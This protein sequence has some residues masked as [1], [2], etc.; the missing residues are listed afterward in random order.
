MFYDLSFDQAGDHLPEQIKSVHYANRLVGLKRTIILQ[1]V[2][3]YQEEIGSVRIECDE[4]E[5]SDNEEDSEVVRHR[6]VFVELDKGTF[7]IARRVPVIPSSFLV[8]FMKHHTLGI[9][10]DYG[11]LGNMI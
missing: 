6:K 2:R 1:L 3:T 8:C 11:A 7:L 10:I 4:E 9:N 5:D